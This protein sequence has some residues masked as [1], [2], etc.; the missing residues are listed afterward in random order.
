[1]RGKVEKHGGTFHIIAQGNRYK[2][3]SINDHCKRKLEAM[4]IDDG[5]IYI[6]LEAITEYTSNEHR[7]C[8]SRHAEQGWHDDDVAC[9]AEELFDEAVVETTA[10]LLIAEVMTQPF[11]SFMDNEGEIK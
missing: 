2:V 6:S 4:L 11:L 9:L 8:L 1:M 5:A 10:Q 7:V 3:S